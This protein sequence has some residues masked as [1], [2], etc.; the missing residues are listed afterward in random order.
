MRFDFLFKMGNMDLDL[1]AQLR[2]LLGMGVGSHV[3]A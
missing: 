2:E 3:D 1:L